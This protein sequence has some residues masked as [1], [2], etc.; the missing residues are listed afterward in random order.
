VRS[1]LPS[2]ATAT[3]GAAFAAACASAAASLA[4]A[5]AVAATPAAIASAA[6]APGCVRVGI[7]ADN[8]VRALPALKRTAGN[9]IT[10]ISA[11]LTAGKSIPAGLI[12]AANRDNAQL[13]LTWE[14]DDGSDRASQPSH[15]LTAVTAGKYDASLRALVEQLRQVRLGAILRPMPE[16]NTPWHA[17]SGTVNH[18][19]PGLFVRAW[20]HIR[21][22]VRSTPG[23]E[24]IPLL[25]APYAW[26]TPDTS[27]NAISQYFPGRSQVDLVGADGY[28]FGNRAPLTWSDPGAVF[29]AA[30]QQIESLA[31][32]PFWI[33]E[34]GSTAIGG[35][36]AGWILSLGTLSTTSMPRLAGV[37]WYDVKDPL[38]DF[39]LA[40]KSVLS[41]FRSLV[42]GGCR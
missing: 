12:T 22:V 15:R 39:R 25:W 26:S 23:G 8:L 31:A 28:N 16:M 1:L 20:N 7:Y 32:K 36:K 13:L 10:V 3:V 18:N 21:R 38:G 27:A 29:S 42:A 2:L 14:P 34:T 40:G 6:A 37:V 11:Y 5:S 4:I 19:S 33:A 24:Q 9:G 17:W 30:Y 35:D 41:A